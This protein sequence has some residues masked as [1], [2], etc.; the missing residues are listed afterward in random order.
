M[1]GTDG[2]AGRIRAGLGRGRLRLR[3]TDSLRA[4]GWR[5][6]EL[7]FDDIPGL[8]QDRMASR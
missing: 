3:V 1:S 6:M 5:A 2:L 4:A 7:E 8:A